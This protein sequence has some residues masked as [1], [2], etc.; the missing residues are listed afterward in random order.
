MNGPVPELSTVWGSVEVGFCEVLQ[1]KP[2]A[3]TVYPPSLVMLPPPSAVV[4]VMLPM[5]EVVTVGEPSGQL[6]VEKV[7]CS[8]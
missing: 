8:P 3:V 1:H 6:L 2:L 7:S 5:D 4:W